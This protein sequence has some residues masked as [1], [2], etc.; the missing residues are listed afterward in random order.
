MTESPAKSKWEY[1]VV[2]RADDD[3]QNPMHVRR[4]AR[5][6]RAN[7]LHWMITHRK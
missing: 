6:G 3:K 2:D 4:A 5:H 7:P 1:S